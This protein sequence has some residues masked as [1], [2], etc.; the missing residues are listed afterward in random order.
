MCGPVLFQYVLSQPDEE[1][2]FSEP[3]WPAQ[4]SNLNSISTF[5]MNLNAD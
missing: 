3:D 4:S 2:V 5:R 1:M